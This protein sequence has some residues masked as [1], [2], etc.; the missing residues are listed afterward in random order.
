MT[1]CFGMRKGKGGFINRNFCIQILN[2]LDNTYPFKRHFNC[3]CLV[4]LNDIYFF[5]ISPT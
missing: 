4:N 5:Y 2:V 1:F 3:S